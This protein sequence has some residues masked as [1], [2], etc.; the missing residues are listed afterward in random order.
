MPVG[1]QMYSST[2]FYPRHDIK[3]VDNFTPWPLGGPEHELDVSEKRQG[4]VPCDIER[5][6]VQPTEWYSYIV[7]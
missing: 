4:S 2:H 3:V 7:R 5:P 6:I 1:V